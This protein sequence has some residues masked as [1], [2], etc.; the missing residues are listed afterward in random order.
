MVYHPRSAFL[1]FDRLGVRGKYQQTD[2][3][4]EPSAAAV[5]LLRPAGDGTVGESC[6][7]GGHFAVS[8][9]AAAVASSRR[10]HGETRDVI[11]ADGCINAECGVKNS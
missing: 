4:G 2:P 3:A 6:R 7:T 10:T 1:L 5:S 11:S 8:V 9:R